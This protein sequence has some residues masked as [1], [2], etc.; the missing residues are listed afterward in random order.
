MDSLSR[1]EPVDFS[2][3]LKHLEIYL[4]L[5][6]MRFN[7]KL[8]IVYDLQV[9]GFM[10]PA[11]TVQPLAENA[12]KYGICQKDNGGTLTISTRET[13]DSFQVISDDG[14]GYDPTA[15][16]YDGRTHIGIDNVRGRLWAMCAG[17][18]EI[19][20]KKGEGTIAIISIPKGV[21]N[22]YYSS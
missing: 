9:T 8:N 2:E 21:K 19:K 15:T 18:L 14:V 11:L 16:Q 4:S 10:L 12:V 22:E 1:K 13:A 20:S 7:K 17:R 6:K 5:E 3:E